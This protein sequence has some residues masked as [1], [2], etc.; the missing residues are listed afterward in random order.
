MEIWGLERFLTELSFNQTKNDS[1]KCSYTARPSLAWHEVCASLSWLR[2]ARELNVKMICVA[3][4]INKMTQV[5]MPPSHSS[6][7][8]IL[9]K[10]LLRDSCKLPDLEM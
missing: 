5:M 7:L 8:L 4:I 2:A 10:E 6:K 9:N 1:N 3:D